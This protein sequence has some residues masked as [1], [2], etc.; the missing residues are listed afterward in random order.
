MR[1]RGNVIITVT[2]NPALDVTYTVDVN[3]LNQVHRVSHVVR[4]AGGKG[5]NVAHI[6][7][8][9]GYPV[10]ATG[11]IGGVFGR[12]VVKGIAKGIS[13]EWISME[14]STRVTTAIVDSHGVTLYNEPGEA[15]PDSKWDELLAKLE[16]LV[17]CGDV[18]V[19][20]G[21][22][23]PGLPDRILQRMILAVKSAGAV[24]I[25]D[26]SGEHL[27]EAIYAGADI[28][29]PNTEEL[30][31]ATGQTDVAAALNVLGENGAGIVI[32]SDGA[33]GMGIK[34]F[35][36]PQISY[37]AQPPKTVTGNATGAGDAAVA[38]IAVHWLKNCGKP[39]WPA[40][41][42]EA[43]SASAASVRAPVAGVLEM[44]DYK[45]FLDLVKV[46]KHDFMSS[47][48]CS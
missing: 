12:E 47:T 38:A 43:V 21:S 25:V 33:K 39:F 19:I 48:N 9:F 16:N 10:F 24:C 29:K 41:L 31:T 2:C 15:V 34:S 18:V 44:S 17:S 13:Q 11:F 40:A 30:L 6:A 20:A 7:H 4:R 8:L 14:C 28:V 36:D 5:I 42:A 27:L 1:S 26:T 3:V 22:M 35:I 45:H 37:W 32:V 46:K 23:P